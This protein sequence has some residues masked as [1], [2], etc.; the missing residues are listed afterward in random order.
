M[1]KQMSSQHNTLFL[2][3]KNAQKPV[4]YSQYTLFLQKNYVLQELIFYSF[5]N[6]PIK[7]WNQLPVKVL[8]TF[9]CKP[10]IF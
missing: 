4:K 8:V 10:Y 9:P 1:D 5:V 2:F 3:T 6:R 7:V